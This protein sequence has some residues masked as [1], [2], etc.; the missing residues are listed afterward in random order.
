MDGRVE[1]VAIAV[2]RTDEFTRVKSGRSGIDKRPVQG[3][4]RLTVS[5]VDGDTICDLAHHGGPD[6][7]VYAYATDDLAYWSAELGRPVA[8]VGQNLTLSGVDCSGAVIGERWLV[9]DAVLLVRGPRIPCRMFAGFLDVPDMVRRFTAARRPGCYLAVEREG[10]VR[11]GD[12]V[13]VL[14][15]PGHGVTVT[16]VVAAMS[17]E[18]ER[19]PRV[20]HA[21][22]HLGVR[23]QKWLAGVGG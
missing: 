5:G 21:A 14:L 20:R 18:R 4:V 22:A 16:D 10:D 6:Q 9:G 15:R 7:A 3:P 17:G 12:P 11:S 1:E 19:L 13:R 2:V 23:G 8:T